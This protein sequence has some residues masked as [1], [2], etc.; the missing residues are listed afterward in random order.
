MNKLLSMA[1][2]LALFSVS[3]IEGR[4]ILSQAKANSEAKAKA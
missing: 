2:L 1:L 3:F 4:H